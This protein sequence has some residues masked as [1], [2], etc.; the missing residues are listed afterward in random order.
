MLITSKDIRAQLGVRYSWI[1][2][3][4]SVVAQDYIID[5]C[6]VYHLDHLIQKANLLLVTGYKSKNPKQTAIGMR[7]MRRALTYFEEIKCSN[8]SVSQ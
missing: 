7:M 1:S 5:Q 6:N 4:F 3:H 2:K 8:T